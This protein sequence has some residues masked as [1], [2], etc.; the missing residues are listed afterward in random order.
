[1]KTCNRAIVVLVGIAAPL[2][3]STPSLADS[4]AAMEACVSAFVSTA[5]PK[6]RAVA[7][8]TE[9]PRSAS[10]IQRKPYSIALTA[11]GKQSG[12][13]LAQA[14]CRVDR[15]GTSLA[16]NGKPVPVSGMGETK[17]ALGE[18]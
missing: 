12:R 15:K 11:T 8:Q 9:R 5:L 18:R 4:T 1:M 16:L 3:L 10:L 14:T 17:V 7:V 13:R 2:C 6:D